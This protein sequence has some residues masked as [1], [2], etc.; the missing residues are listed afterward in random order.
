MAHKVKC[1]YCGENFDR[2]IKE[3]V[4]VSNTRYAHAEC[5][6]RWAQE[7]NQPSPEVMSPGDIVTCNYC[8]MSFSKKK[9]FGYQKLGQRYF[10][11]ECFEKENQREHTDK[12]KLDI[13]IMELFKTDYVNPRIQKQIQQYVE[14]YGYTYSGIQSTLDYWINVKKRPYNTE[15]NTIS[16]VPHIYEQAKAYYHAVYL[17]QT[18]NINKDI[19]CYKPKNISITI[20][21]PKEASNKPKLFSFLDEEEE[22]E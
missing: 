8:R 7:H 1:K 18:R 16:L 17:A 12:E 19:N 22:G 14:E 6:L 11:P 15:Y 21:P 2:D 9:T 5:A 20:P 4:Q 10:H 13:Y 3:F